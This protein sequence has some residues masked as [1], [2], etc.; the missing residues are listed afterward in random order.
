M[1]SLGIR[2]VKNL[3]GQNRTSQTSRTACY[4]HGQSVEQCLGRSREGE[5]EKYWTLQECCSMSCHFIQVRLPQ[6]DQVSKV[7]LVGW[8]SL[9][10]RCHLQLLEKG[11]CVPGDSDE[12]LSVRG[13]SLSS[14]ES[15]TDWVYGSNVSSSSWEFQVYSELLLRLC[16]QSHESD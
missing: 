13:G 8:L 12:P 6:C 2:N 5:G 15:K 11:C 10:E 16:S 14:S 1:C 7:L 4:G 9:Q 3:S